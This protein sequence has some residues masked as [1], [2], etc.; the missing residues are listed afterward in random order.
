MIIRIA[1]F[2]SCVLL[3]VIIGCPEF[4]FD[5]H[6][7]NTTTKSQNVFLDLNMPLPS[8][9]VLRCDSSNG[10]VIYLRSENLSEDL[11]KE[12]HFRLL[13]SQNLFAEI[14]YAFLIA[15]RTAFKLTAPLEELAVTSIYSDELDFKHIRFQQVFQ[16]ISVWASEI[17][18]H[19]NQA[20]QVYLMQG[21][22]I[23][24]PKNLDIRPVL[25]EAKAFRIVAKDLRNI[26]SE[27]RNCRS[28][29][30]VFS[31]NEKIPCLAYRVLAYTSVIEGWEYFVDAETGEILEKLTTVYKGGKAPIQMKDR[32]PDE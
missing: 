26:E 19:L 22:Y 28:E 18:V 11:E 4:L 15:H 12:K 2:V 29:L 14:T 32:D 3:L 23:P 25:N 1:S 7:A 24:T 31:Q 21:R 27:C 30:I 20:N 9:A 16:G 8:D 10:T 17:I 6:L 13:Q 5:D